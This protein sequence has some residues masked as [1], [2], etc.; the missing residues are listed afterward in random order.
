MDY[1]FTFEDGTEALAHYGVKGMKWGKHLKGQLNMAGGG[2]GALSD[3]TTKELMEG[4]F[5]NDAIDALHDSAKILAAN[6]GNL[7][8]AMAQIKAFNEGLK[9][10]DADSR[11]FYNTRAGKKAALGELGL[12]AAMTREEANKALKSNWKDFIK[13]Y[14]D[15]KQKSGSSMTLKDAKDRLADYKNDKKVADSLPSKADRQKSSVKR[16]AGLGKF[17]ARSERG[18]AK[19]SSVL[20]STKGE[21][22]KAKVKKTAK[23]ASKSANSM[24]KNKHDSY[25][26]IGPAKIY[27]GKKTWYS[28]VYATSHN[29]NEV[30]KEAKS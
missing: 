19:V 11:G 26:N 7:P 5:D 13:E 17:K 9:N 1:K 18:K 29:V 27:T 20:S 16:G 14:K 22:K 30:V 4:K 23:K 25:V 12:D 24:I 15:V 6:K 28:P 3:D 21:V 2:G 10:V 8:R